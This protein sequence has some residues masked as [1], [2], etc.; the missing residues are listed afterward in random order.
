MIRDLELSILEILYND[1]RTSPAQIAVMTGHSEEEVTAVIR[2]LEAQKIILKYPAMINWDR[3]D[4]DQVEAVIEV[5]VTPQRD[6]GFDA[7]AE[8][9]YRFDEVSSVYLMSGAYDLMVTVKASSMK[10]L[11]LFVAEK[12]STLDH[13]LSTATHFV[14]KKYKLEGV[15]FEERRKDERLVVSP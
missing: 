7:I 5:R 13:V 15:I 10:Q 6:E 11:A 1:S 8:E 3:V 4:V 14:L 9:I 2:S 12:L